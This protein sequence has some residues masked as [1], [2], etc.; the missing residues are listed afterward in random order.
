MIIKYLCI[1]TFIG[2]FHHLLY[3]YEAFKQNTCNECVWIVPNTIE[4]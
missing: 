1:N 4:E 2:R 3:A